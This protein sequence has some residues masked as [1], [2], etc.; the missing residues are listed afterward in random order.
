MYV[1]TALMCNLKIT[2]CRIQDRIFVKFQGLDTYV[3]AALS[4]GRTEMYFCFT[5][6]T[7][8]SLHIW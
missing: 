2:H 4:Q 1:R 8:I 6:F 3:C 7:D 5:C